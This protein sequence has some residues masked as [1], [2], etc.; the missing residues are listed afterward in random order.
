MIRKLEVLAS[1][2]NLMKKLIAFDLDGTLAQSKSPIG[3]EMAEL[4]TRLLGIVKVA[5]ISGGAWPQFEKQD[6]HSHVNG[7]HHAD[8]HSIRQ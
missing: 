1:S 5:V 4:L 6:S 8:T 2:R 3:P 7:F